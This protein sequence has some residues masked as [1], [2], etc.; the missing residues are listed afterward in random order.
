MILMK[1]IWEQ[2]WGLSIAAMLVCAAVL[3][4]IVRNSQLLAGEV[5]ITRWLYQHN[6]YGLET[7][8]ESWD[9]LI[10]GKVAP[11]IWVGTIF[12]AWWAWGRYA[13]ATMFGAGLL[14][15]P[16]SLID[17]A[18][19]PRPTASIEWG[20]ISGGGGYP[21]GHVMF[22]ILVFGAVAYLAGRYMSPSWRRNGV[23]WGLWGF[24]VLMGPARVN[25][26]THWPADI[27]AS[28]LIAFPQLL[29]VFWLYP[30]ALPYLRDHLS[31]AYEALH[32]S[33]VMERQ[34]I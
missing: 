6:G 34:S 25:A 13:G 20:A 26:L 32:G 22:A 24:I 16:V 18:A 21:S 8:A 5:P 19:R 30:R 28:Y 7:L 11:A 27:G 9:V 29:F 3:T 15:A 23:Q 17:L 4:V 33:R 14:T 2:R 31:W 10:T 1:W 12:L